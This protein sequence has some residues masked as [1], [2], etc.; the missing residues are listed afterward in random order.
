MSYSGKRTTISPKTTWSGLQLPNK[1]LIPSL[2]FY[3]LP[4][5]N[6]VSPWLLPLLGFCS[7]GHIW[8]LQESVA[9]KQL[10]RAKLIHGPTPCLGKSSGSSPPP[11]YS[12]QSPQVEKCYM[13]ATMG[14][15]PKMK[16]LR[17]C[18]QAG[19]CCSAACWA[20]LQGQHIKTQPRISESPCWGWLGLSPQGMKWFLSWLCVVFIVLSLSL[21]LRCQVLFLPGPLVL[22]YVL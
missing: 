16:P 9:T 11:A 13:E 12:V 7:R 5:S 20:V 15:D 1:E 4:Y 14:S 10:L 6:L 18:L 8:A 2:N 3:K 17:V 21:H 22:Q 19:R